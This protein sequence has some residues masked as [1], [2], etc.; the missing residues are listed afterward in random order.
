MT[1]L[2]RH[3]ADR[4]DGRKVGT[5]EADAAEKMPANRPHWGGKKCFRHARDRARGSNPRRT[6]DTRSTMT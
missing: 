6:E 1:Y 5:D 3:G 4:L 2:L